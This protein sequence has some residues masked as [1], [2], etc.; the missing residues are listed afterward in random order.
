MTFFSFTGRLQLTKHEL[1]T[2]TCFEE[3]PIAL[4][5]TKAGTLWLGTEPTGTSE[6]AENKGNSQPPPQVIYIIM[7]Q[8]RKPA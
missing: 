6:G 7:R 2:R 3:L 4:P 5:N 1:T 8:L